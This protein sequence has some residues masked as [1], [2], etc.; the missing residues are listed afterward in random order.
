M[1]L[2][3]DIIIFI[4]TVIVLYLLY[5]NLCGCDSIESFTD[6]PGINKEAVQALASVVDQ[7]YLTMPYMIVM[8]KGDAGAVPAGWAICNGQNGTPDLR[9][10]FVACAGSKKALNSTGGGK[11]ILTAANLPPHNHLISGKTRSKGNHYHKLNCD[12]DD[13][14]NPNKD[15]A[16]GDDNNEG[17]NLR[18]CETKSAGNHEHSINFRSQNTGNGTAFNAEPP[19]YALSFIMKLPPVN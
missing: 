7:N 11:N 13:G 5:N 17:G 14:G 1:R 3:P 4:I 19:Y 6:I 16:M 15:F 10:K 2:Y 8:Y 18:N 9:D 12:K